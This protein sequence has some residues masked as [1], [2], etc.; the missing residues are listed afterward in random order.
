LIGDNLESDIAGGKA[1]GMATILIL[2]GV[3]RRQ[4]LDG[5]PAEKM[6]DRVIEDL[7]Q[8]NDEL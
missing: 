7:T 2:S 3:T 4:D 5:L 6:P 8:I 1:M